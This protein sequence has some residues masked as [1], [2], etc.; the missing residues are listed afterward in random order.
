MGM[1]VFGRLLAGSAGGARGERFK[2]LEAADGW[3]F[4]GNGGRRP[5]GLNSGEKLAG[6]K[7]V[8]AVAVP[9]AADGAREPTSPPRSTSPID[10]PRSC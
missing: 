10:P 6:G 8:R 9:S 3:A 1:P 7:V 4:R 2:L 5:G